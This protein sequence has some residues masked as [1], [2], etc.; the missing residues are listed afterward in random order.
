MHTAFLELAVCLKKNRQKRVWSI[1]A[2]V[3]LSFLLLGN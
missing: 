2:T 1:V 3:A